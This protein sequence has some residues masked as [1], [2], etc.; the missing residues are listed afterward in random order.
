MRLERSDTTWT[1]TSVERTFAFVHLDHIVTFKK[2]AEQHIEN[3]REVLLFLN[4][5]EATLKLN[6]YSFFTDTI[7]YPGHLVRP[8]QRELAS[9]TIDA[10]RKLEPPTSTAEL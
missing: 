6:K 3:V 10:V 5:V 8:T 2:T 7:D 9:H 4:K 1:S